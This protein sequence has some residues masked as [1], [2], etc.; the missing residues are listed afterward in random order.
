[1]PLRKP[2]RV[3][4]RKMLSNLSDIG[5]LVSKRANESNHLVILRVLDELDQIIQ[6]AL[7]RP[8]TGCSYAINLGAYLSY[9]L[10]LRHI[11]TNERF[12]F[13]HKASLGHK[14][15]SEFL[16]NQFHTLMYKSP[17]LTCS[18]CHSR[19]KPWPN[20]NHIKSDLLVH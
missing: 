18:V 17:C 2:Y 11:D 13:R 20:I 7:N 6:K 10:I 12:N 5:L 3:L 19:R 14:D 9:K 4:L 1:M 8:I 15:R 16:M